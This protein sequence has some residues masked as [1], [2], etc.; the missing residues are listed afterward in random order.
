M[1]GVS[2]Y[3]SLAPA[4][5]KNPVKSPTPIPTPKGGSSKATYIKWS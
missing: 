3:S 1:Q 5:S 2:T 4:K